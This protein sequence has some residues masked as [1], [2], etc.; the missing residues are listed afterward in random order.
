MILQDPW[1]R[2][3]FTP[4]RSLSTEGEDG[5]A[6]QVIDVDVLVNHHR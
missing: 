3:G 6:A 1:R 2:P 4:G 5:Q